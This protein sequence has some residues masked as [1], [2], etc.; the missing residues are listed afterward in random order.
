MSRFRAVLAKLAL[1]GGGLFAALVAAEL[2]VRLLEH[3]GILRVGSIVYPPVAY[4]SP[5]RISENPRLLWELD[6]ESPLVNTAGF[7]DREVGTERARGTSR[8]VAL[9]DS[10]TFGRGVP[11]AQTWVKVLEHA[12]NETSP[13]AV[14]YE[15]LNFGVGG[16]NTD[17]EVELYRSKAR[18]YHPDLIL[19]GY[20]LNDPLGAAETMRFLA[21]A[22]PS[23]D[24]EA[25]QAPP[26]KA[27]SESNRSLGSSLLR[28]VR[29]RLD[30]LDRGGSPREPP[31]PQ[32]FHGDP[33]R[34]RVVTRALKEL[35]EL[36]A[37]DQTPVVLVI[38][39][40]LL[41][42][43]EYPYV[44]VHAQ[45]AEEARR[46]GLRVLD[47]QP[48]LV[49]LSPETLQLT[50]GDST[51]PSAAGHEAIARSIEAYLRASGLLP[52]A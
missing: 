3:A 5:M 11:L 51:H 13:E 45:V 6:P 7:R 12:L 17:Q 33:G 16:Y 38:L 49:G 37:E 52:D 10:V 28:L 23:T 35:A 19:V 29:D 9:G 36:A 27:R 15:V 30:N 14:R 2:G 39:P 40:L 4:T 43:D 26:P 22:A 47:L 32:K 50:P 18:R 31:F 41:D 24:G 46:H 48:E 20:V 21:G 44:S 42:F 25:A 1:A 8:I 34:W